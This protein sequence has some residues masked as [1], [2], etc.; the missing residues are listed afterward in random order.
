VRSFNRNIAINVW[1]NHHW[2]FDVDLAKCA[3]EEPLVITL[4]KV[5]LQGFSPISDDMDALKLVNLKTL[6]IQ[7][8]L[9]DIYSRTRGGKDQ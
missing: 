3:E 4:D 5:D 8:A 7:S 6:R 9:E 2:S 1:W